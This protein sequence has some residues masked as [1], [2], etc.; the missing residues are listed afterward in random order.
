MFVNKTIAINYTSKY[1]EEFKNIKHAA[2][3]FWQNLRCWKCVGM[4]S[5]VFDTI[6]TQV[7]LSQLKLKLRRKRRVFYLIVNFNN[8]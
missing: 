1:G 6:Y 2:E 3:N 4:W 8:N 7:H 5:S